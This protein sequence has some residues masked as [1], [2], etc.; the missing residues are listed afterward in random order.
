MFSL[1][2]LRGRSSIGNTIYLTLLLAKSCT[3]QAIELGVCTKIK[4]NL[5]SIILCSSYDVCE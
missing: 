5:I 1:E 2:G 4:T 3:T